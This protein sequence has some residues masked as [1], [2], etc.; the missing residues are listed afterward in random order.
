MK[1]YSID[2]T[3]RVGLHQGHVEG[4]RGEVICKGHVKRSCAGG[5]RVARGDLHL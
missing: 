3:P 4:S 1:R 5:M 2:S